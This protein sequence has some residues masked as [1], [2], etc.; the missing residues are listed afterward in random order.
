M[1]KKI[2]F[3]VDG[4]LCPIKDK[5]QEYNTLEPFPGIVDKIKELKSLGYLIVISTAR[6]MRYYNGNVGEINHK[7]LPGLLVWL[8]KWEIPFDEVLVG[9]PHCIFYIDDKAVRPDEFLKY[10]YED[11]LKLT[12][13][14]T[15]A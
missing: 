6:N 8:E 3:D 9:K 7:T 14:D 1:T 4:T 10:S 2:C 13:Q 5:F 12:G 11:L 15:E